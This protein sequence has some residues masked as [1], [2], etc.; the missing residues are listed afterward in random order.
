M[1]ASP[2]PMRPGPILPTRQPP[3]WKSLL[4][5]L[6][7]SLSLLLW[8]QGLLDSL[9]RPSVG[10]ALSHRQLELSALVSQAVHEPLRSTLFGTDPQGDL[11]RGIEREL[12]RS[13]D[14]QAQT[15]SLELALLQ[16]NS[17]PQAS[18]RRISDLAQSVDPAR[19]AL[20]R[21]LEQGQVL[22]APMRQTLLLPWKPSPLLSQLV[23][24]QMSGDAACPAAAGGRALLLRWLVV[25]LLPFPLMLVGL[26]LL[27]RQAWLRWRGRL[28]VAPPWL[29]PDL[30]LTDITLLIAGGFVLLGEVLMPQLL[31]GPLVA[32]LA[33]LKLSPS[34]QQGVQVLLLYLL[35]M[36]VPLLILAGMLRGRGCPPAG[37]WLQWHWRP[38]AS[39]LGR[40]LSTLLMALPAV[41]LSGW[42]V[43]RLWPDAGGSNPL[44]DLVLTSPDP[45]AL[46]CFALTASLVAPLF[47]EILFRGA[48]L[49][50]LAQR[51]GGMVG[52]LV[53]AAVFALAHLSLSEG[54]P[55][56]VL[57]VGLGWLRWRSGR[58]APS[59]LMHALWNG[60]TLINLLVLA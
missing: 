16:R 44:L 27:L 36:A 3:L 11:R 42:L 26:G 46:A 58:L 14:S 54:V 32:T 1:S 6:C 29:G 17:D 55:L 23:C 45:W 57:G 10:D 53:S 22:D 15:L 24:E 39:G 13:S 7:L 9:Q 35:V 50:V 12:A 30:D 52:V 34:L 38:L 33:G 59:V 48:L 28:P 2:P 41:A 56:F 49:P 25:N 19:M 21:A 4:A 31:Q 51:W 37:G 5:L 47:E 43:E 20:L 18:E 8:F 40:A 60:L